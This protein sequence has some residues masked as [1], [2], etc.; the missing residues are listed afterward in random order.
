MGRLQEQGRHPP[1]LSRA[2]LADDGP[3]VGARAQGDDAVD[4]E[5]AQ[6]LAQGPP[7]HAVEALHLGFGREHVAGDEL[8]GRDVAQ[9]VARHQLRLLRDAMTAGRLPLSH[10]DSCLR[11]P[12]SG[13]AVR[14]YPTRSRGSWADDVAAALRWMRVE[15]VVTT[16]APDDASLHRVSDTQN[17]MTRSPE[18]RS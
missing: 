1:E 12:T 8:A 4:L 18:G 17:V 16:G 6:R 11:G 5:D 9:D 13:A 14:T 15:R 7:G 2:H 10:V 3:A